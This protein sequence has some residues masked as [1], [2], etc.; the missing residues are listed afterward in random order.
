MEGP[1]AAALARRGG[2]GVLPQECD[3]VAVAAMTHRASSAPKA[4]RTRPNESGELKPGERPLLLA[5]QGFSLLRYFT[6]DQEAFDEE[7]VFDACIA[8]LAEVIARKCGE[9][10]IPCYMV[11]TPGHSEGSL[12]VR[13]MLTS[14]G[15]ERL[16][17]PVLMAAAAVRCDGEEAVF[18]GEAL[19]MRH[20][21]YMERLE[22]GKALD[23]R[24]VIRLLPVFRP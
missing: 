22:Q 5:D 1:A 23:T 3:S 10:G 17:P 7:D 18:V 11:F 24:Q 12:V 21:R 13:D 19:D 20:G 2:L 15:P 14:A 8:P 16:T 9:I 4:D 6:T